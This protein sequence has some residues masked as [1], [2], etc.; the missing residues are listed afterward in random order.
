MN[1][2]AKVWLLTLAIKLCLSAFIPLSADEAYYWFWGRHLEWSYL[3]HPPFVAW[4]FFLGEPFYGI[5]HAVRWPAVLLGHL[6]F[7]VWL[8]ILE[9]ILNGRQRLW[10]VSLALVSP[11]IGV[12][13]LIVTPDI[14]LLFFWALSLLALLRG[15]ETGRARWYA[16]LGCFLGLGFCSKYPIV[17]FVPAAFLWLAFGRRLARIR[18]VCVLLTIALGLIFS[19]P[20]LYWNYQHDFV[21]FRF[22][23]AHGLGGEVWEPQWTIEYLLSQIGI[24]FPT[25]LYLALRTWPRREADFLEYF[26]WFPM[27]FFLWSSTRGHVEANWPSVAYA[28]FIALAVINARKET[29]L[30]WTLAIWLFAIVIAASDLAFHW[31]PIPKLHEYAQYDPFV[32]IAMSHTPLYV[33]SHQ[34]AAELSY[35]TGR[36]IYKLR[37]LRRKDFFDFLDGSRPRAET[38][39]LL[40]GSRR[41][42]MELLESGYGIISAR[43]VAGSEF[44]LFELRKGGLQH[45]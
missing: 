42:P 13:S 15:L 9:P 5:G 18:W 32:P 24:I 36:D 21:S 1:R 2:I 19:F 30:K 29:L 10:W 28:P 44:V 8:K 45:P 25:I 23:L 41:F 12:G 6:T 26:A 31:L 34:M 38:I 20:V 33:D 4:L 11:F 3:D 27:L 16:A 14:P 40:L 7:L 39:F 35:K 43:P 22:Q 37:G 17:L